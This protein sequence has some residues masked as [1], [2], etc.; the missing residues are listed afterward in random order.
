MWAVAGIVA[1]LNFGGWG[2]Y[3]AM[4]KHRAWYEGFAMGAM[5]GPFGP[6]LAACMPT[7]EPETISEEEFLTGEKLASLDKRISDAEWA[8]R[9]PKD[10]RKP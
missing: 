2:S 9:S 10:V 5:L 4:A 7:L 6:V 3:V 1:V 8:R